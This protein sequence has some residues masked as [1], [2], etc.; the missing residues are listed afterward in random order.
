MIRLLF[1][2]I[3]FWAG[4]AWADISKHIAWYRGGSTTSNS[5]STYEQANI[6]TAFDNLGVSH[7]Y[8]WEEIYTAQDIID[9]D[10]MNPDGSVKY[11]VVYFMGGSGTAYN[12][13]LGEAGK[14]KI[15]EFVN[16][17]GGF[18]GSCAG[19]YYGSDD[20]SDLWMGDAVTFASGGSE[21]NTDYIL[22]T[23]HTVNS[24]FGAS[25]VNV[26]YYGGC[27]MEAGI[28]NT[29]YVATYDNTDSPYGGLDGH[30]SMTF[31]YYGDGPVLLSGGHPEEGLGV[32][33]TDYFEN[34]FVYVIELG[35]YLD[36]TPIVSGCV[37][38]GGSIQ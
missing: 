17:A 26:A 33:D 8:T 32:G 20:Y 37:I 11:A 16:A 22:D 5:G 1:I 31:S 3:L 9:G 4:P 18:I 2:L 21:I 10:L 13:G 15:Q 23:G 34:M 29:D 30:A 28:A 12:S 38:S 7:G 14:A 27:W 19:A 36:D 25:L 6:E 24:G 35:A